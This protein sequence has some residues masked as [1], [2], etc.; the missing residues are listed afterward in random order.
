LIA[1]DHYPNPDKKMPKR[2]AKSK[3]ESGTAS[4]SKKSKIEKDQIETPKDDKKEIQVN[5]EEK[6]E[7]DAKMKVKEAKDEGE[8]LHDHKTKKATKKSDDERSSGE[9]SEK[10]K[11]RGKEKSKEEEEEEGEEEEVV[12][13][14]KEEDLHPTYKVNATKLSDLGYKFNDLMELVTLDKEE[15]FKFINQPHYELLG[16]LVARHIQNVMVKDYNLQEVLLPLKTGHYDKPRMS[17]FHTKEALTTR[18]TLLVLI[19]G[20]GRVMAGQWARKLCINVSLH[21]GSMLPYLE[22]AKELEF[23]VIILNPNACHHLK[24]AEGPHKKEATYVK[25]KNHYGKIEEFEVIP[26][27]GNETEFSHVKYVWD[28]F[29]SKSSAHNVVIVAHSFGGY[30]ATQLL[31]DRQT[32]IFA[33]PRARNPI[34]VRA[35]ALSDSVHSESD[36]WPNQVKNFL[37]KHCINFKCSDKPLDTPLSSK[38]FGCIVVSAGTKVHEESA[39]TAINPLFEFLESRLQNPPSETKSKK[40]SKEGKEEKAD[41]KQ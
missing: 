9:K 13:E 11:K 5:G 2:K 8:E 38:G 30:L 14:M 37:A 33:T 4:D 39:I 7:N 40:A 35:I 25:Q 22:K 41:E 12:E 36:K 19:P 32:Q 10:K 17:I 28:N 31:V 3:E 21:A 29:I 27:E 34:K 26:V 15:P 6:Q 18:D 20:S 24:K 23:E 16:D 1:S